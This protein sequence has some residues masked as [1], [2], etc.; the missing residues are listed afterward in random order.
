[1]EH[2]AVNATNASDDD[3]VSLTAAG[4][5]VLV[6]VTQATPG[7]HLPD[8]P[9]LSA[10]PHLLVT[11]L[12]AAIGSDGTIYYESGDHHLDALRPDG[13]TTQGPALGGQAQRVWA[14]AC[15]TSTPS[16]AGTSGSASRRARGSMR[17]Y[18]TYAATSLAQAGTFSGS[19][20]DTVADTAAGPLV[21]EQGASCATACPQGVPVGLRL[22]HRPA[23]AR[24]ATPSASVPPSRC[25]ARVPPSSPRTPTT[26]QFDLV[27]LS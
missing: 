15:R 8:R 21:L 18:T 26:D 14:A 7:A 23:R 3:L 6:S 4:G 10:A 17:A 24:P 27:R 5:N 1:M 11:A 9:G 25:S 22:P 13:T 20:T 2:A 19:V 16:P 12:G